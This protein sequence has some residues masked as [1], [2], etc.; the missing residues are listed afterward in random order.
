MTDPQDTDLSGGW[1]AMAAEYVL[2]LLSKDE[3]RAFERQMATDPDLEQDVAAWTEYFA[4][5]TDDLPEV[6]PPPQV[7]NRIE[8]R[9]FSTPRPSIWRQLMPYLGG[10]VAAA[11]L[12]WV[13]VGTDLLGP[14]RPHLYADL[15]ADEQGYRLLAHWA[16]DSQ[17]FM[18]RRD[19]GGV[20][21]DAALE[22]WLIA[23]AGAA[24]VSVGLM[25]PDTLT[26]IPVPEA[27]VPLMT[28]G[29]TVAISLEPPGGSPTGQPT[30]PVLALGTLAVRG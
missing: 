5:M 12:A 22:I 17:T 1:E 26:Q 10:A 6:A 8:Q 30:G 24:P 14:T 21:Q 27:L 23:D 16:P 2:G 20:P 13:V 7:L 19:A 3:V 4:T 28:D 29:A 15:V 11:L 25:T 9:L 18:L